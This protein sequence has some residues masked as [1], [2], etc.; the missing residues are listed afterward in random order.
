LKTA[1][2]LMFIALVGPPVSEFNP[3]NYMKGW[4]KKTA[5]MHTTRPAQLLQK[6]HGTIQSRKYLEHFQKACEAC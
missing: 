6:G 1:A 3:E 5:A 4:L 2:A